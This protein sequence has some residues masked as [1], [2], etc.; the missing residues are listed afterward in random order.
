MLTDADGTA[1]FSCKRGQ[2]FVLTALHP[3]DVRAGRQCCSGA[4]LETAQSPEKLSF[5]FSNRERREKKFSLG[6]G[7][8][9]LRKM[10]AW[11]LKSRKW[12]ASRLRLI[13]SVAKRVLKSSRQVS[14]RQWADA[15]KPANNREEC[16]AAGWVEVVCGKKSYRKGFVV[17]KLMEGSGS[18][19]ATRRVR[20]KQ[21]MFGCWAVRF[22]V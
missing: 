21:H 10:C 14:V 19:I 8:K 18:Q 22:L 5:F 3:G 2:F 12:N 7:S 1:T 6:G 17:V 16:C 15:R 11:L 13:P 20:A 9:T 4:W